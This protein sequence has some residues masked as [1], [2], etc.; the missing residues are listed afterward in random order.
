MRWWAALGSL[1][2]CSELAAQSAALRYAAGGAQSPADRLRIAHAGVRFYPPDARP[3]RI[4]GTTFGLG[5]SPEQSAASFVQAHSDVF[6]VPAAELLPGGAAGQRTQPVMY[7]AQTG[8]YKFTLVYYAQHRSG[9]PVFRSE[10]RL[11]VRN[12][13]DAGYPLVLAASTLHDLGA[14]AVPPHAVRN[15]AAD[16]ART[17]ALQLVPGLT[18]FTPAEPVIWAGIGDQ[19]AGPAVA[20]MFVGQS[21]RVGSQPYDKWRFVADAATGKILYRENLIIFTDVTGNVSGL[22]TQGIKAEQCAPE[23]ATP[24]AY[25][26]AGIVGGNSTFAD[27]GGSF[28]IPNAGTSAVTVRSE[29][30]GRYFHVYDDATSGSVLTQTVTPPGPASFTHN[31]ANIEYPRAEVN[32]YVQANVVRD[33]ALAYNPSFPTIATQTDFPLNVNLTDPTFCPG[34][35]WYDGVSLNFCL[36]DLGYP[37]T[38]F[39]PVVHH[40][41]GHHLIQVGSR[42]GA[43][44]QYGEGMA[45]C[46]S[47]LIADDPILAYGFLGDCNGGIRTADNTLQYPCT[48][49][50]H[51][52]AQ[53]LSGCI[54]STR[55]A[56]YANYPVAY[57]DILAN[58]TVNSILLHSGALIT[59][60]ITIDFLTLDDNDANLG[61][62]T[63]HYPEICAGFG[64]HGMDCPPLD[65]GLS[66]GPKEGLTAQ[67]PT[68]GP[69]SPADK[70]YTLESLNETA[71]DYSVTC[72]QP[73][74]TIG[75]ATGTL[76]PRTPAAV[77]VTLNAAAAQLVS[78]RYTDTVHFVNL[79][80]HV[81]DTVRPVELLVA[82]D[83]VYAWNLDTDPGWSPQGLWA[84]GRPL[85]GGGEYGFPDPTSGHTGINVYGYNLSGDYENN[86]PETYLTTTA[87]DCTGLS[88]TRLEFW[89][90]LGVES[91]DFDQASVRV[92]SDRVNWTT[93]WQNPAQ[94]NDHAWTF[95]QFDIAAIADNRPT[96]YIRWVMGPTDILWRFC[97]WNIDDIQLRAFHP[98]PPPL[99]LAL[100]DGAP[101][102]LTP[103]AATPIRVQ[104][105]RGAE[106]YVPGSGRLH[107]RYRG[108][109]YYAAP[110]APLGGDL[111]EATL[112]AAGCT[113][114][115]EFYFSAQGDGG[116]A[117]LDP[118]SAPL[119]VYRA[120]VGTFATLL[121]DD[122]E[123]DRGWT[124]GDV[125]D[126]ATTGIWD[127]ADPQG[128]AAQ[129]EDDH[130][131]APGTQCWVTDHR[132]GSAVGD[133]DVDGGK[134]TLKS[135]LL[136]V[137]GYDRVRISYYRWYSNSVGNAP[138]ADVF[139]V[140]V[141]N[142]G[143]S[144][145]VNAETV[146][147]S[148]P[149]T[150]GGWFYH[151]FDLADFV[152]PTNQ[153]QL[154]FVAADEG[155]GSI[156]EAAVDDFRVEVFTCTLPYAPGDANCDGGVDFDDISAFVLALIGEGTYS[157][158]YPGCMWLN[159][160]GD[161]DGDVT[162][163]DIN[164]FVALLAH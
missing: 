115:P 141:S 18:E 4:Y 138:N 48:Q 54:W 125:G 90:W 97:G 164:P 3:T 20:V 13:P 95:Q 11:L 91:P 53:L 34:N 130:T 6:G 8:A 58:L 29:V 75:N 72:T 61:N 129:P 159:G 71:I 92:S 45:D 59:P 152:T 135:P 21:A 113:A 158:R 80:D 30:R 85:G 25:A 31:A 36:A 89:R 121:A 144:T 9:L 139:K 143:G 122:F 12:E 87:I 157:T 146:G 137:A 106:A 104:I 132:A 73:W 150:A 32:A 70:E 82:Y 134:T 28:V 57:L 99:I 118:P 63:P 62:G 52:C 50:D 38:A 136:A 27:A 93:I 102:D 46:I 100:P 163:D 83:I 126:N 19:P 60:Q 109:E 10:L 2:L 23:V 84:W 153:V 41:Y 15:L 96:L 147:P 78:G 140:D 128:T 14:F 65:V 16:A 145:W 33:F 151:E 131:P 81:G 43:Q 88:Q 123:T 160:D 86:L 55:N 35:A 94:V 124:F 66:V 112:P 42:D 127:R 108:G 103:G 64:A 110:L 154:R 5:S 161:G 56:L 77:T 117:V 24:L 22:A 40:E 156:I 162:F 142:S 69:F 68:G 39:S 26:W 120:A 37:N 101:A 67:G 51:T 155:A 44:G 74:L 114:N 133:Y 79:T 149:E 116:G 7:D 76:A 111:Y 47:V 17:A 119:S 98:P 1:A 105:A 49:D 148:G 107:W